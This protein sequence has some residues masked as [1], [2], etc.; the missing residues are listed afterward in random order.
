LNVRL[1]VLGAGL[2]KLGYSFLSARNHGDTSF[3][4][5][6]PLEILGIPSR[7]IEFLRPS[8]HTRYSLPLPPIRGNR[9]LPPSSCRGTDFLS[10]FPNREYIPSPLLFP[11]ICGSIQHPTRLRCPLTKSSETLSS[12]PLRGGIRG[13]PSP[14]EITADFESFAEKLSAASS[15][16]H[17]QALKHFPSFFFLKMLPLPREI[18]PC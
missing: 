2:H 1:F 6:F 8:S 15:F 10:H 5:P 17:I 7:E 11:A 14:R 9:Y 16:P 18:D 12:L 3:P 13:P 4:L